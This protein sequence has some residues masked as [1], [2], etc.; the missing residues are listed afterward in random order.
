MSRLFSH[1]LLYRAH[2]GRPTSMIC[3]IT[4]TQETEP[5]FIYI[6]G[7]EDLYILQSSDNRTGLKGEGGGACRVVTLTHICII[8]PG[9][10]EKK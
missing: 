4:K 9:F 7:D 3:D 5:G 2:R 8:G 10:W 6:R 1:S